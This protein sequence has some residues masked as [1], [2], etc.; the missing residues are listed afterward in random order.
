MSM[1]LTCIITSRGNEEQ[2][3]WPHKVHNSLQLVEDCLMTTTLAAAA[4]AAITILRRCGKVAG[5]RR[6]AGG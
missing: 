5:R 1:M 3:R 2:A 4:A 6:I